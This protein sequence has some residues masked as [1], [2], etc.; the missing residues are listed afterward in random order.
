MSKLLCYSSMALTISKQHFNELAPNFRYVTTE[1]GTLSSGFSRIKATD[2]V[3]LKLLQSHR[4]KNSRKLVAELRSLA[5]CHKLN[6]TEPCT[7]RE[8]KSESAQLRDR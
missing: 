1:I 7:A 4:S 5:Q 6:T 3:V 8:F 2:L